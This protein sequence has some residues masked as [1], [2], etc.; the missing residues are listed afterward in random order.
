MARYALPFGYVDWPDP[1]DRPHI[2]HT[3]DDAGGN[4]AVTILQ[5]H[6][7]EERGA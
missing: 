4:A 7:P 5:A 6:C 3:L 2:A 1:D